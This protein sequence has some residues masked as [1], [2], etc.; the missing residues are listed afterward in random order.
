M[1][2]NNGTP[3]PRKEKPT[4]KLSEFDCKKCGKKLIWRY[5]DKDSKNSK[6]YS[7]FGCSGF[8]KCKQNYKEVNKVPK[9]E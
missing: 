8:P 2:D 1:Q 5:S 4:R 6:V 7:L 9:Y 3:I